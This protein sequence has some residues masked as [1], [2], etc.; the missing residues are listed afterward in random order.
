VIKLYTV[1]T[2]SYVYED[3][4]IFSPADLDKAVDEITDSLI[5]A[6]SGNKPA[7][8]AVHA[9]PA[10]ALVLI[11]RSFAGRGDT[12][13]REYPPGIVTVSASAENYESITVE[14]EL[15]GGE[16]TEIKFNLQPLAFGDVNV[17][18]IFNSGSVYQGALYVG[19]TPLTLQLPLNQLEY[20]E[21]EPSRTESGKAVFHTPAEAGTSNFLALPASTQAERGRVEKA[22]RWYYWGWS[23]TWITG[24]T[25]MLAYGLY[26]SYDEAYNM[27]AGAVSSDFN[28]Q[29]N[30]MN[31]V[32]IGSL[33]VAGL[34]V[35]HEIFQMIRYI[36]IANKDSTPYVKTSASKREA[37]K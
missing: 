17:T 30:A 21:L 7:A 1:Y 31:Y 4:V 11:N 12:G 28:S 9:E 14:T 22:R 5:I 2:Q 34:A 26:T 19:L 37:Q 36:S 6:L 20:I 15:E 13:V 16:L 25:A 27:R 24:I 33:A 18:G 10:E 35:A 23:G 8:I 32:F 29:Y 3:D